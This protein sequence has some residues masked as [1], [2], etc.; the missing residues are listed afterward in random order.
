MGWGAGV[1]CRGN[2]KNKS[3]NGPIHRLGSARVWSRST[4]GI[5]SH[6]RPLKAVCE[7]GK[8]EEGIYK[9]SLGGNG[10]SAVG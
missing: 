7:G 2:R 1:G 5:H 4:P 8:M 10:L 3:T 6:M 9:F